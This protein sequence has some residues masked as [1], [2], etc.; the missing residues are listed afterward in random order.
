M[1]VT[2]PNVIK[3]E[4]RE[5]TMNDTFM[6]IDN[7][8]LRTW[9]QCAKFFNLANDEGKQSATDYADKL[10]KVSRGRMYTMYQLISNRG[11]EE[12]KAAVNRGDV[13]LEAVH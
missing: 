6:H 2:K 7:L 12:V 3:K 8:A 1:S 10:D 9:N 11:Y 5:K 13:T 4:K